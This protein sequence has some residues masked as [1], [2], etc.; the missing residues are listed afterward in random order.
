MTGTQ[1]DDGQVLGVILAAGKGTRIAPFSERFPK[2]VLP[3]LGK[4]LIQHQVECLRDLGVRR[5][6]IVI[7]HLGFEIVRALGDGSNLGVRIEYVD[8]GTTLGI[9][10]ALGKLESRIDRPFMLFLGDIFFVHEG[11]A[12]MPDL[13]GK[14]DVRGVLAVKEEPDLEAVKR[15]FV[16]LENEDGFVTRVIEKP[17]HP[18]TNLKGCGLY[19]FDPVFFDAVRR[20]PR[21]AMRDEYEITDAIQIFLEDGNR[22]KAARVVRDDLNLSYPSDLLDIN[23]KVLGNDN[24]MGDDVNL[25]PGS[26]VEQSVLMDGVNV[27]NPIT[28]RQSLVFPGVTL[29]GRSD[30][31]RRI[32]TPEHVIDCR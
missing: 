27:S 2:P 5:I 31:E 4:P 1:I 20:T 11:L 21:T 9:A 7:G 17:Q 15:N 24:F 6:L 22:V 3:I 19:L 32:I 29:T 16:V 14:D 13:L 23:L 26:H 12:E 30:I 28:I 25:A 18:R 8:Q 10:H